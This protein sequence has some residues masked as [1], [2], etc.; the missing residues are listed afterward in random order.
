MLIDAG[1][2]LVTTAK[3]IG[4]KNAKVTLT[5]YAHLFQR[6]DNR[7]AAAINAALGASAVPKIGRKRCSY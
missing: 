3:R 2:D 7:A 1:L 6:D 5:T 4:H